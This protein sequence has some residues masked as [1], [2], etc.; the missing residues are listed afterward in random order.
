M[1]SF[2]FSLILVLTFS[3]QS[4]AQQLVSATFAGSKTKEQLTALFPLPFIKYGVQYYRVLY[5]SEDA[6][7]KPDTLSGLMVVPNT[8]NL[9]F[10]RLVYQHGTADCK[11]CV[12]SNYGNAGGDEGQVGL[13]FGGLGFVAMLPDYVGMGNGRGFQSYVHAETIVS[14]TMDMLDA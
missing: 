7:G 4:N 9:A 5:T 1:K 8:T 13:L 14:A 6:K 3:L 12:P 11:T 10:P 2:L